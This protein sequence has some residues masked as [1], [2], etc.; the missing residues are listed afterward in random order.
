MQ[1]TASRRT[2]FH[3]QLR[4]SEPR[5]SRFN[6]RYSQAIA[7]GSLLEV[8]KTGV[9][10]GFRSHT[11]TIVYR[12]SRIRRSEKFYRGYRVRD[13]ERE[14]NPYRLEYFSTTFV[15]EHPI[16]PTASDYF[17]RPLDL[18]RPS[19]VFHE[20]NLANEPGRCSEGW[21]SKAIL[22]GISS[23]TSV[24]AP[25]RAQKLSWISPAV[26]PSN[27]TPQSNAPARSPN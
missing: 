17:H 6:V 23:S 13:V 1:L 25:A 7:A 18:R 12:P 14:A 10:E 27:T 4:E 22:P 20:F 24:P 26:S 15:V 2:L 5:R 19:L 21:Y 16:K 9:S 11:Q 3:W 8:L